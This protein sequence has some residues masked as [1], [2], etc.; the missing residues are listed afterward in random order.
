MQLLEHDPTT[1]RLEPPRCRRAV[2]ALA[3]P[4][5]RAPGSPLRSPLHIQSESPLLSLSNKHR[6]HAAIGPQT[7]TTTTDARIDPAAD[8]DPLSPLSLARAH[9][10]PRRQAS[11]RPDNKVL[12]ALRTCRDRPTPFR[13]RGGTA[14][15]RRSGAT[16]PLSRLRTR[17]ATVVALTSS[18][19]PSSEPKG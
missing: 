7:T 3:P 8:I 11:S 18:R 10:P 17:H 13:R 2:V 15:T 1:P 4:Q 6:P 14:R 19:S 12:P 9:A 5:D 16:P